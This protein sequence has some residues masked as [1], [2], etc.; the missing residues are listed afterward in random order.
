MFRVLRRCARRQYWALTKAAARRSHLADVVRRAARRS[1]RR[2]AA[3]CRSLTPA[4]AR[5][6]GAVAWCRCASSSTAA[7][8]TTT[9]AS[10]FASRRRE[11]RRDDQRSARRRRRRP[12]GNQGATP[13]RASAALRLDRIVN[14]WE[15]HHQLTAQGL[16]RERGSRRGRTRLRRFL[17]G[18]SQRFEPRYLAVS[19]PDSFDFPRDDDVQYAAPAPTPCCPPA[20]SSDC[21]SR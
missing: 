4:R 1:P 6:R 3:S 15:A 11:Q 2:R 20:G 8:S 5:S 7:V 13:I 14:E 18:G 10:V 17:T 19:L 9:C 21:R 16:R 12:R